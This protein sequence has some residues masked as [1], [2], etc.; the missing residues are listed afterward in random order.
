MSMLCRIRFK[1]GAIIIFLSF[2]T[3]FSIVGTMAFCSTKSR[4]DELEVFMSRAKSNRISMDLDAVPLNQVLRALS[5]QTGISFLSEKKIADLPIT[6]YVKDVN[7]ISFVKKLLELY[8]LDYEVVDNN[9]VIIKSKTKTDKMITKIFKLKHAVVPGAKIIKRADLKV[10]GKQEGSTSDSGEGGGLSGKGLFEALEMV[11]TEKGRAV[12][13]PRSNSILVVDLESNMPNIEKVIKQLDIEVPQ[14]MVEVDILDVSKSALDKMGMDW[15]GL[16]ATYTGWLRYTRFPFWG[17][18]YSFWGDPSRQG[19]LGQVF[20]GGSWVLEALV[21]QTN[22]KYLARPK[23][24]TLSGETAKVNILTDEVIGIRRNLDADGKVTSEEAERYSTGVYL[25]VTPIANIG[26]KKITMV[27]LPKIIETKPSK[28]QSSSYGTTFRDPE[29]RGIKSV[30]TVPDGATVV[31]GG[32]IKH[33]EDNANT[34]VPVLGDFLKP[35]FSHKEKT[36]EDRELLIF[37]TPHI[38]NWDELVKQKKHQ[39][40]DDQ[41]EK[42][43]AMRKVLM[44][45]DSQ[46][47]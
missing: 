5:L 12:C 19:N 9:F 42:E 39:R 10:T 4:Y 13:D 2:W 46:R 16:I 44:E 17:R 20:F 47:R 7:V 28:V 38:L 8:D 27:V 34:K 18:S 21:S 31:L 25:E 35:L 45:I 41:Q 30:V 3:F 22:A 1:L 40:S 36:S 14:I 11:L 26:E 23:V 24:F 37:I 6:L 29:E 15:D 32:L 43:E 33:S